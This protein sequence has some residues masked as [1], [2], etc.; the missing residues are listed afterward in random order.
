MARALVVKFYCLISLMTFPKPTTKARAMFSM[1]KFCDQAII[2]PTASKKQKILLNMFSGIHSWQ[3]D[4]ELEY[5]FIEAV[6]KV[7]AKE[8]PVGTK[9]LV[10]SMRNIIGEDVSLKFLLSCNP[11]VM[12]IEKIFMAGTVRSFQ[13]KPLGYSGELAEGSEVEFVPKNTL[14]IW[15]LCFQTKVPTIQSNGIHSLQTHD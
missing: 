11:V 9:I 1:E 5:L 14:I 13:L 4:D 6:H 2:A 3:V 10:P 12:L 15:H 7:K 8:V